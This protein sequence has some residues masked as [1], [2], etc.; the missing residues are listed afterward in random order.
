MLLLAA[1]LCL[2]LPACAHDSSLQGRLAVA[3]QLVRE[4]E[5]DLKGADRSLKAGEVDRAVDLLKDAKEKVQDPQMVYYAD[6]ENMED[7]IS[8]GESRCAAAKDAKERREVAALI[9]E[10]KEKADQAMAEFRAAAD[11]LQDRASLNRKRAEKAREA[12]DAAIRF[13]DE[14]K[15]F[16]IDPAWTAYAKAQ[17][18]ELSQRTAQ[19][20][21]AESILS[22]L[23]GPVARSAQAKASF[24]KVKQS[25]KHDEKTVLLTAARDGYLACGTD[26]A[27]LVAQAPTLERES[28]TVNGAKTT[29][30]A[31]AAACEAQARTVDGILN[32]GKAQPPPP[33]PPGKPTR[34]GK[35]K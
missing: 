27:A 12:F 34:P 20:V 6:R 21:V 2:G 18:K 23:E 14:S 4:I 11:A 24:E 8:Q 5:E 25:K 16:E 15:R 33:P 19:L 31:F 3:E 28:I 13:L 30:K 29:V 10:R 9:P 35:R 22:F 17:R 26:A 1:V 32:P 7:R